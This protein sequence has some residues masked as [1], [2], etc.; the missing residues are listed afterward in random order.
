MIVFKNPQY[1]VIGQSVFLSVM[2]ECLCVWIKAI[3]A[4]LRS[5]PQIAIGCFVDRPDRIFAEAGKI[6]RVVVKIDKSEA[7]KSVLE[8]RKLLFFIIFVAGVLL[9][10]ISFS[11]YS[12]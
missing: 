7:L 11:Y 3:Q 9:L 10:I 4:Q 1:H 2:L 6:I 5:Q 12:H 8:L